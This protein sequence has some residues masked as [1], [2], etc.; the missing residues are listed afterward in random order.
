MLSGSSTVS[1]MTNRGSP[2]AATVMRALKALGSVLIATVLHQDV[3]D[4][5]V[6]A[7]VS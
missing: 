4:V 1:V 3:D 2:R 7:H 5:A 6:L